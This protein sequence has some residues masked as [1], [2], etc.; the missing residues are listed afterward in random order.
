MSPVT[1][2]MASWII[3]AKTTDNLRDRRLVALSGVLPD[4]DG[5][6]ILIDFGRQLFRGEEDFI[7]YARYH[8]LLLHGL[9]AALLVSLTLTCF[10]QRR[11]R[12]ALLTF[13]VFHLH[14]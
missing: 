13:L 2:L 4:L 5:A 10:A 12:V 11:G 14:L 6:G 8:H 3:A 1:H 7:F 9:F